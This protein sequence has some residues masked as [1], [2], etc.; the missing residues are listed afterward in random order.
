MKTGTLLRLCRV[1]LAS[2][3]T[4]NGYS[5]YVRFTENGKQHKQ[6]IGFVSKNNPEAWKR[7]LEQAKIV[8]QQLDATLTASI[9]GTLHIVSRDKSFIKFFE[10]FAG[11]KQGQTRA[12][13]FQ[14]LSVLREFLHPAT[15]L[16]FG[17]LSEEFCAE[18]KDF[19]LSKVHSGTYKPGTAKQYFMLFKA[20]VNDA[21]KRKLLATNPA[22]NITLKALP[23]S[24]ESEKFA[25]TSEE[26]QAMLST[27]LDSALFP[28]I[29]NI[30]IFTIATAMRISDVLSVRFSDVKMIQGRPVLVFRMQ[31]TERMH[32]VP[33]NSS[34]LAVIEKQRKKALSDD[35]RIFHDAPCRRGVFYAFSKWSEKAIGK[36]VTPHILR[37]TA[38]TLMLS[39][40]SAKD[41][42]SLLGH[43]SLRITDHYLHAISQN[44]I[45]A[46]VSIDRLLNARNE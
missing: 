34:A 38:A 16:A 37:H 8:A 20:V 18:F 45:D 27:E 15:D 21:A 22:E 17:S 13:Y 32:T 39:A 24:H 42:S 3:R 29:K 41:V 4:P 36:R 23:M 19:L 5:L 1:Q 25:L 33:L 9:S 31:K 26:I 28:V 43:K 6:T 40:A 35:A 30:F 10:E 14:C 12:N 44:Q 7:M 2:R 46:V 11:T